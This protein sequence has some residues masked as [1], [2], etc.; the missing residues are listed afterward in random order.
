MPFSPD[1]ILLKSADQEIKGHIRIQN[2]RLSENRIQSL[3]IKEAELSMINGV[4]VNQFFQNLVHLDEL[5]KT[6]TA[7]LT[8]VEPVIVGSFISRGDWNGARLGDFVEQLSESMGQ[9]NYTNRL[10]LYHMVGV[11]LVNDVQSMFEI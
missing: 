9:S 2:K 6:T 4:A 1:T 10:G 7:H 3:T 11:A 8:F 5:N